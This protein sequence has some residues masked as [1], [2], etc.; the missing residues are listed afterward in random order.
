MKIKKKIKNLFKYTVNNLLKIFNLQLNKITLSNNYYYHIVKTLKFYDIDL[1]IDIGANEGQFAKEIIEYGYTKRIESFE[2]MKSAFIKLEKNSKK[3]GLWKTVNLGFGKENSFEFLNISKNSVSSS[4]LQVLETSTNVESDTKF[5][6]R[7]KI[8]LITLNEYLSNNEYKDK[9]IFVKIDTQGYEKNIILGAEKVKDKIKGF[10]VEM[11]IVKL[12]SSEAS[13]NEM[14]DLL[15]KLGF[16]LWSL[17]RGFSNKKT[18]QT[19]QIDAIFM[20]KN[21]I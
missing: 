20:N 9:K 6:S 13:F 17:E 16:E 5:I 2:P 3:S 19:L 10:L 1:V 11:S 18:G 21:E 14:I 15:N 4:I 12:Y 8:K 7:E